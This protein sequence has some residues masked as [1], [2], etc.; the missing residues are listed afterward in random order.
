MSLLAHDDIKRFYKP[1]Q[2]LRDFTGRR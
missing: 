1:T 2:A